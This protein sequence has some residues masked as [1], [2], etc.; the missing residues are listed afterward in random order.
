MLPVTDGW[1]LCC[2]LQTGGIFVACFRR[3]EFVL[4]VSDGWG[5]CCLFQTGGICVACFKRVG[6]V[7]PVS[8]GWGL[9][10]LFQTGGVCVACFRRVGFVLPVS[11]GWNLC[12]LFQTGGVCVACFRRVGFVL[13][14]SDGWGLC[15]PC[16]GPWRGP[17]SSFSCWARVLPSTTSTSAQLWKAS[18]VISLLLPS[19]CYYCLDLSSF[20]SFFFLYPPPPHPTTTPSLPIQHARN[21]ERSSVSVGQHSIR[22]LGKAHVRSIPSLSSFPNAAFETFPMFL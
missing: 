8:D 15:C 17:S 20:F 22:V 13:P 5:L 4:P 21:R 6:F 12:C 14:V 2:L 10:C 9:C 18:S 19:L 3:V 16:W 1:G 11:D 7:L